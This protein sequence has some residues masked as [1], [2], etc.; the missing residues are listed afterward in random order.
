ML[1]C[2]FGL[3][4]IGQRKRTLK[5]RIAEHKTANHTTNIY[6]VIAQHYMNANHD[7]GCNFH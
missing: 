3:V 7:L 4:Y 1:K 2:P 6:Y 5:L